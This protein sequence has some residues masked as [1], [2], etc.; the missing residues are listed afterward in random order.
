MDINFLNVKGVLFGRGIPKIC[1]SLVETTRIEIIN[2]IKY[3]TEYKPDCIELRIDYFEDVSD[4]DQV[5]HLLKDIKN[6]IG[7]ILL[8]FTF[9]TKHEGGNKIISSSYYIQL[10]NS[11]CESGYIDLIDIEAYW[12]DGILN[13]MIQIAHRYHVFVIAS[14]HDF[15]HTPKEDEILKRLIY[16]DLQGA[17]IPKI[18]VMPQSERDVIT[19][20]SSSIKYYELGYKKPIITISMGKK[21]TI[22][23]LIGECMASSMTFASVGDASAPGQIPIEEVQ[24]ITKAIHKMI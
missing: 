2:K 9:R 7:D 23:R 21:G 6:L 5:I 1:V 13:H 18:A 19:L 11:V 8:L 24:Y 3:I 20:I 22:T 12:E 15:L 17:D 16:M 14:N 4:I 10:C